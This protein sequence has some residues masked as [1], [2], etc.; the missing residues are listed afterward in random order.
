MLRRTLSMLVV[1]LLLLA[2]GWT[3][4]A[5]AASADE[6]R[7]KHAAKVKTN[8]AKLGTGQDARVAVA[9]RDKTKV[10]GYLSAVGEESFVVTDFGTGAATTVAYPDVAQVKGH[11]LTTGAKITIGVAIGVGIILLVVLLKRLSNEQAL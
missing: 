6:K 7:A 10:A 3:K 11:N 2:L 1:A 5:L 4:P 9:L 8:V